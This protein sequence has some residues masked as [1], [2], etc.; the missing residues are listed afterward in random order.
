MH[1]PYEL[2]REIERKKMSVRDENRHLGV[3]REVNFRISTL[4]DR[5][6]THYGMK[7]RS[8]SREKSSIEA[9]RSD[10]GASFV[11]EVDG[12]AV[13]RWQGNLTAVRDLSAGIAVR[14]FNVMH[15]IMEKASTLWSRETGI[16]RNPADLVEVRRPDDQRDRDLSEDELRRVKQALDEKTYCK[17]TNKINKTLYR[18]RIVLI[19][20]TKGD[21][22]RGNFWPANGRM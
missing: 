12:A 21:A 3:K 16:D 5:N 17:G 9:I 6:W 15:H 1:G 22:R 8:A 19:A 7:K 10:L 11:C 20:I 13:S 18:V 2:A 4:I 14:H